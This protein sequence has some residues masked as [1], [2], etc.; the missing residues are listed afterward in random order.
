MPGLILIPT[1][2]ERRHIE[3]TLRFDSDRWTISTIGFG[4]IAAA[5][6]T[7]NALSRTD[8]SQV[9]L[10]GIAGLFERRR[11]PAYQIGDAIWFDSVAVDG[12]GVGQG[13]AY[14]D[15][16]ELGWSVLPADA[17]GTTL[18]LDPPTRE[19][20]AGADPNL[21]LTVCAGSADV[22]DA[23]RRLR[24]YPDAVGEDMEAFS[25]AYAC[26]R[27]GVP[28]RVVRGFSNVVGRR[29]KTQWQIEQALASVTQQLQRTIDAHAP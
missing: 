9:I 14:V 17:T 26:H 23:D 22:D 6:G 16:S 19:T 7:A 11:N 4:V 8:P 10:A 21:L 27:A 20:T 2:M 28:I 25:V 29:D 18:S 12:I 3:S 1:D 15:A 24:R 5:V 13:D